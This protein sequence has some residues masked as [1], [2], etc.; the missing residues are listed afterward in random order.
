MKRTTDT[1]NA[2][3]RVKKSKQEDVVV[4]EPAKVCACRDEE[5][6]RQVLSSMKWPETFMS[7]AELTR[8]F[9]DAVDEYFDQVQCECGAKTSYN[10]AQFKV[11]VYDMAVTLAGINFNVIAVYNANAVFYTG[12]GTIDSTSDA[13]EPHIVYDNETGLLRYMADVNSLFMQNLIACIIAVHV[14]APVPSQPTLGSRLLA[15]RPVKDVKFETTPDTI[16]GVP[17][18]A[19][20]D[21]DIADGKILAAMASPC[22]EIASVIPN[23]SHAIPPQ[24]I[25]N[26]FVVKTLGET[27]INVVE[28]RYYYSAARGTVYTLDFDFDGKRYTASSFHSVNKTDIEGM[29][30]NG[31]LDVFMIMWRMVNVNLNKENK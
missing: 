16:T 9:S 14:G 30:F 13:D 24:H 8:A 1:G 28:Y 6:R 21:M 19:G 3:C 22:E 11:R 2:D 25:L 18:A 15:N 26:Q 23:L 7:L 31:L 12:K 5:R 17:A 4:A 27:N 29:L 10:P 20:S